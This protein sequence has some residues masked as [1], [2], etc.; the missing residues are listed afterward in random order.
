MSILVDINRIMALDEDADG[1]PEL[2]PPGDR[3]SGV[4]GIFFFFLGKIVIEV[5][6]IFVVK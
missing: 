3:S 5:W 4:Q 2:T 1:R 6:K